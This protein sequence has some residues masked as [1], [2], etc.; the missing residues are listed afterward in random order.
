LGIGQEPRD[1]AHGRRSITGGDPPPRRAEEPGA[2]SAIRRLARRARAKLSLWIELIGLGRRLR[3]TAPGRPGIARRGGPFSWALVVLQYNHHELTLACVDSALSLN[4]GDRA[5]IIVVDN[6][7]TD[8]SAEA[9]E[10][11]YED[12]AN[13]HVVRLAENAGYARGN[14]AGYRYARERLSAS[15]ILMVNN[16]V[17]FPD[18]EILA[19]AEAEYARRRFSILGPDIVVPREGSPLH[20]NPLRSHIWTPS[21]AAG[22]IKKTEDRLDALAGGSSAPPPSLGGSERRI[23][24]RKGGLVALHGAVFVFSP[25]FIGDFETPFDECTFLYGEE[26]ILALRALA[27]GHRLLYAP[28]LAVEHH[29]HASTDLADARRHLEFRYRNS[30]IAARRYLELLRDVAEGR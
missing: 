16:D 30:L 28:S 18:R 2:T 3:R 15:F 4:G 21:E 14:N 8:G 6:G 1:A 20:Q 7:S 11:R 26:Y 29:A 9:A 22:F 10:S 24:R 13:I 5:S 25:A 19:K 27:R 12:R 23:G 17:T